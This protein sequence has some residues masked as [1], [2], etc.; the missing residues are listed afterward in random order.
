MIAPTVDPKAVAGVTN[1]LPVPTTC[2]YCGSVVTLVHHD[3]IYGKAYGDW[4]YSYACD[5]LARCNSYVGIHRNTLIP[6]GTLANAELR[7][8]RMMA[9]DAF[10]PLWQ[11]LEGYRADRG[12]RTAAYRW[13]ATQ[14]GIPFEE[15][16]IG[17]FGVDTCFRVVGIIEGAK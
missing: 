2:P 5:D 1:P 11:P 16:H 10:N 14:L 7:A 9:K 3:K 13:L 12:K 6:L 8:M 4:P 17:W 15:C